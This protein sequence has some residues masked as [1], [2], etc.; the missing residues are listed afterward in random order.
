MK[1]KIKKSTENEYNRFRKYFVFSCVDVVILK[2]NSVLLTIRTQNPHKGSWHIP[3][4]IIRKNETMIQAVKRAAN[5][6]LNLNVKIK[7]YIGAYENL[8]AYR[9]DISHGFIVTIVSGNIKTDFQTK[10]LKFFKKIPKNTISH[11]KKMI[12]DV[13]INSKKF[14]HN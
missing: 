12:R 14:V 4:G 3:G 2:N 8:N 1:K 11:H 9:H 6:E 10:E 7:K 13:L 5:N